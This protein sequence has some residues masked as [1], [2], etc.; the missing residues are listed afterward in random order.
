[1][2]VFGP[3]IKSFKQASDDSD[4]IA[5][6]DQATVYTKSM[7][8]KFGRDFAVS[9]YANSP[10]GSPDVD[11][12]FEQSWRKPDSE[13]S[14]DDTYAVPSGQ[15]LLADDLIAEEWAH[16]SLTP[17]ALPY[18]RLKITGNAGNPSDTVLK[19]KMSVQEEL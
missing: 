17:V 15:S 14:A 12:A 16:Q 1:M 7:P 11:I 10:G 6:A 2:P 4:E 5:V 8:L 9:I 13:G 18:C 3:T 19:A